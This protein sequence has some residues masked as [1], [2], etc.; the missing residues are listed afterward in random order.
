MG[1][2]S[3]R[4]RKV[5]TKDEI[6]LAPLLARLQSMRATSGVYSWSLN[7]I[8]NARDA[9]MRGDFKL[10]ARLA[11][12]FRTD[13]AM[14]N[15]H[16]TRLAPQRQIPVKLVPPSQSAAALKVLDEADALFGPEGVGILPETL[17]T[18]NSHLANH[19]V[20]F[21]VNT[22]TPR[23]DGSR[24]DLQVNAW[25][26]EWV[27]WDPMRR[28]YV[29]R[30]DT[31]SMTEL[32]TEWING[33][34][35][36]VA[37]NGEVEICHGDGRWIV[38]EGSEIEPWR[39]CC[40]LPGALTWARHA[41]GLRDWAKGSAAHGNA[42]VIGE[43]PDTTG[44]NTPEGA[45]FLELLVAV[46]G[47]DMPVGIKPNGSKVD[48]LTNNSAAWQIFKELVGES[49]T[50]AS[51]IYLG[52][53]GMLGVNGAGPGVDLRTLLGVTDSIAE[54]DMHTIERQ[55]LTGAIE[56]WTAVNF[57][58]SRLAPKRIYQIPDVDQDDRRQAIAAMREAL[59]SAIE[60]ERQL[61]FN[62]T[63]ARIATL[64]EEY[65]VSIGELKPAP[66]ISAQ[67]PPSGNATA[68]PPSPPKANGAPR[69]PS[70]TS[71]APQ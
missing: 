55:L 49:K 57:G 60:R 25:P 33:A 8:L 41:F 2:P 54:G 39:D 64:A 65:G 26:I 11:E 59:Y 51:Q 3:K 24:I 42:K 12:S 40:L 17:V 21:A 44:I 13:D 62:V 20:A 23:P 47:A 18:I 46:A 70:A 19:G 1:A 16:R 66:V 9:Q 56:I 28:C 4:A 61:G 5:R 50:S 6:N 15:A 48:Y 34:Y 22:L 43:L 68:L 58:D 27:R 52:H 69:L 67:I 31:N 35:Q 30:V 38:F 29:T 14:Y 71:P 36:P 63:P 53:D 37:V 7:D 32:A 45:Q 10:P